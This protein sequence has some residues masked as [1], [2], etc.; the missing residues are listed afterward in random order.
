[1]GQ[2][3]PTTWSMW[4][5]ADGRRSTP[6]EAKSLAPSHT[7]GEGQSHNLNPDHPDSRTHT[8]KLCGALYPQTRLVFGAG[9]EG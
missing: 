2:A 8:A 7:A 3:S 9:G 1:M 4:S 6:R 5:S